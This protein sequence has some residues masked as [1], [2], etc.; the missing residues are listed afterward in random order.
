[1]YIHNVTID[2]VNSITYLGFVFNRNGS[3]DSMIHDRTVKA[4][5]VCHMVLQALSTNKNVSSKL[6]MKLFDKQ[7]VPIILYGCPIW[8][9]PTTHKLFYLDNQPENI[10]TKQVVNNFLSSILSRPVPVFLLNTHAE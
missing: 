6:A 8:A 9:I 4:S 3:I 10:S 1:M 2:Y 7:I 5:K